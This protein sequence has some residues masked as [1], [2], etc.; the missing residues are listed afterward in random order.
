MSICHDKRLIFIHITKNAGSSIKEY[1]N[2]DD[3]LSDLFWEEYKKYYS[4][5]WDSYTKFSIVRDPFCRFVSIYQFIL[6]G[7]VGPNPWLSHPSADLPEIGPTI[8]EFTDYVYNNFNGK[9]FRWFLYPQH[10]F[11]CQGDDIMVDEIVRFESLDSDL[12]RIGI[13]KLPLL[14]KSKTLPSSRIEMSENTKKKI[15]ELY[16]KD[17]RIFGYLQPNFIL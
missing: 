7:S 6:G 2:C 14:N 3:G 12:K 8:N 17:F 5:H 15:Y 4:S 1:F 13:T 16:E 9:L 10:K 11:V